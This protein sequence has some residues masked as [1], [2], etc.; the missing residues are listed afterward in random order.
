ML[1]VHGLADTLVLWFYDHQRSFETLLSAA[2][3]NK[4]A[5]YIN[6]STTCSNKTTAFMNGSTTYNDKTSACCK[7][8][9]TFRRKENVTSHGAPLQ[10]AYAVVGVLLQSW[11]RDICM[12]IRL[13][14]SQCPNTAC[15]C[16]PL[17]VPHIPM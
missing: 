3:L 17:V 4:N 7:A 9:N 8:V 12:S 5:A 15:A 11:H 6:K 14:L 13:C 10:K 2:K 1:T 16:S